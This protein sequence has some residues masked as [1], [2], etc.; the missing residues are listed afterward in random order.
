[1]SQ[2]T[3]RYE[4]YLRFLRLD[5]ENRLSRSFC[6]FFRIG[7][8]KPIKVTAISTANPNKFMHIIIIVNQSMYLQKM[9]K[10]VMHDSLMHQLP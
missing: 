7:Y 1:M 5:S 10:V 4:M 8:I 2:T 9:Y 6:S 3:Q